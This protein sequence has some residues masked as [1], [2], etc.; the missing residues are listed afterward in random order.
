MTNEREQF[1]QEKQAPLVEQPAQE[2]QPKKETSQSEIQFTDQPLLPIL[3][4]KAIQ[5][6]NKLDVLEEKQAVLKDKILHNQEKIA[7]LTSR[8]EKLEDANQF[9]KA[10]SSVPL[11][12]TMIEQNE[13]KISCIREKKIP[14]HT[15][16]IKAHQAK[17]ARLKNR[18][19]VVEHKLDRCMALNQV[20]RSF[21]IR[22]TKERRQTFAAAMERLNHSTCICAQDKYAQMQM[23]LAALNEAYPTASSVDKLHIQEKI[24]G[25]KSKM[26]KLEDRLSKMKAAHY[27]NQNAATV[28][29]IIDVTKNVVD[30]EMTSEAPSVAAVAE[31]I[32]TNAASIAAA[33]LQEEQAQ[34]IADDT[35]EQEKV[36]LAMNQKELN[37]LNADKD[38]DGVPDRIDSSYS[39][40][41]DES[42]R[43]ASVSPAFCDDLQKQGFSFSKCKKDGENVII[44]YQASKR[45]EFENLK[46]NHEATLRK[47]GAHQ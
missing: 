37:E 35:T 14:A 45:S 8:A 43:Y 31:N 29:Q 38:R 2:E 42:L 17:I 5:H 32:C 34:K 39:P 44:S 21:T 27:I 1:Q 47:G 46:M 6:R 7:K 13:K 33:K 4:S 11:V 25:I 3:K 36:K 12:Q 28:D 16:K 41:E 10:F 26:N 9:L 24:S 18:Q 22:D 20:L 40:P 23:K 30:T 19:S 15:D